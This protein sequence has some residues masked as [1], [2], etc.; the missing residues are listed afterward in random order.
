MRPT[1]RSFVCAQCSAVW[2]VASRRVA[3]VGL[4]RVDVTTDRTQRGL[5]NSNTNSARIERKARGEARRGPEPF[6]SARLD[7][8]ANVLYSTLRALGYVHRKR[9]K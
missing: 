1:V 6:G 4:S 3:R 2:H 5:A 8:L 7:S 9:Q